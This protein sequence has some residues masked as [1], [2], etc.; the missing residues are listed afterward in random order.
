LLGSQESVV[1]ID[2]VGA[3]KSLSLVSGETQ[4][5]RGTNEARN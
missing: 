3:W 4:I 5:E 2:V 1:A